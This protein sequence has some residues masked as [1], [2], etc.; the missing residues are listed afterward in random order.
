MPAAREERRGV[1]ACCFMWIVEGRREQRRQLLRTCDREPVI[2][3]KTYQFK[4]GTCV[5]DISS[6]ASAVLGSVYSGGK[7]MT[8]GGSVDVTGTVVMSGSS[9]GTFQTEAGAYDLSGKPFSL[10]RSWNCHG[11]ISKE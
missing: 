2:A 11:K 10:S 8:A 1:P 5:L 7:K 3:G 6:P 4:S 9:K